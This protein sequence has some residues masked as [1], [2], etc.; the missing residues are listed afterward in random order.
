MRNFR[1]LQ[2]WNKGIDIVVEVY[3]ITEQL[4]REERFGLTSQLNRAA[5]SVPS[6]IAEGCGR[7][8]DPAFIQFLEYAIGSVFEIDTQLEVVERLK[9]IPSGELNKLKSMIDE[10]G[11]MI[12]GLISSLR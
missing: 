1:E 12:N 4:P 6:N 7:G 2:V 8:T 9:L 5:V 10:E 3:R 11:K